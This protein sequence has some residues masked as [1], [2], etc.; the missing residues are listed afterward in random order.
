MFIIVLREKRTSNQIMVVGKKGLSGALHFAN[1]F[2]CDVL[3]TVYTEQER[4]NLKIAHLISAASSV[5]DQCYW[6]RVARHFEKYPPITGRQKTLADI[7]SLLAA[8]QSG[9]G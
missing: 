3:P 5:I 6:I 7:N 1:A 9:Q 4:K 2:L 8:T